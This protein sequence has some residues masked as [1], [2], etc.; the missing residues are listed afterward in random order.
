V[1][2]QRT[3][4]AFAAANAGLGLL[5]I[6]FGLAEPVYTRIGNEGY[7]FLCIALLFFVAATGFVLK[8][9]WVAL[10]AVIPIVLLSCMFA[11]LIAGG[12]WIWGPPRT[13][14]M[15]L[16]IT[17][18]ILV[19]VLEV[20]GILTIFRYSKKERAGANPAST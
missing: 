9:R 18:S 8:N 5:H 1:S 15:Y 3:L 14:Q 2:T 11:F 10:V 7:F 4:K 17:S 16:F 13:Y 6:F 19:A 12:G 20:V